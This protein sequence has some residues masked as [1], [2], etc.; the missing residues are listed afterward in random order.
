MNINDIEKNSDK[1][2]GK[3]YF[4]YDVNKLNWFNIG[5]KT[6]IYFK[7]ETL[8]DLTL[9][10]NIY[11]NRGKIFIIGAGS[12][13]LFKDDKF[14]GV[15]IKL[16]KN[17]SNISILK[18][19]IIVAGSCALD[20]TISDYAM[21]NSIGGFEFLSCIPGT[22]GGG[23]RMNSGCFDKEFKDILISVQ[24]LE[25]SGKIITIPSKEIIFDYRSCNLS[26][27]LIFLSASFQGEKKE[28]KKIEEEIELLKNKKEDAQP[29]KVKTGGSTFK[30]PK[31]LTNKKVWELINESV[32]PE[33]NFGD[34]TISKKHSNFLIN[35]GNAKYKDMINLINY[36]KKNVH[37]KTGIKLEL[38][39]IVV[40]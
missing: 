8:K 40:E 29:T 6:K 4:D 11:K 32:S 17:F 38:E 18:D 10:L 9:F 2:T 35:K 33:C 3:I 23:I 36:I 31:E 16:S 26:K 20:R 34:A 22:V 14:D 19:N 24:A 28:K 15:I 30:N 37:E 25:P 7:P 1:F 27:D 12:N 13:V 21:K 39:I 5:G